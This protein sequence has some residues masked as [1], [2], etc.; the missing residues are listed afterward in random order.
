[1]S[2]KSMHVKIKAT[3]DQ[4]RKVGITHNAAM[5]LTTLGPFEVEKRQVGPDGK[6]RIYVVF[7]ESMY[8]WVPEE[9]T[10]RVP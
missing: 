9:L 1:M 4:L 5:A 2:L 10:E 7:K 6:M 8:L 3:I